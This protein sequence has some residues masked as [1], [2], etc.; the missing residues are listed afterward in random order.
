MDTVDTNVVVNDTFNIDS[1]LLSTGDVLG[2]F[3]YASNGQVRSPAS[4]SEERSLCAQFGC[5]LVEL[6]IDFRSISLGLLR[7]GPLNL[8]SQLT[9][10]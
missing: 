7:W 5:D 1:E 8:G 10:T 9:N 2:C 4:N 6:A 3:A